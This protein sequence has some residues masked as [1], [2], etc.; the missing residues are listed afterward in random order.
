[1]HTLQRLAIVL[2]PVLTLAACGGG[3]DFVDRV[4]L[5]DPVVRFVHAAPS[6]D[7]L[8]LYRDF[9]NAPDATNVPFMFA[10]D[11]F[12]IRMDKARW[13]IKSV[14]GQT[15]FGSVDIEPGRGDKYSVV[16]V[17]QSASA[18]STSAY[19]IR[20]PFNKPLVSSTAK[21][22]LMHAAFNTGNV[23]VY[24]NTAGTDIN[25]PGVDPLI[26][27]TAFN[28]AGPASGDDSVDI[29]GG[30]YQLTITP[31]GAKSILFRGL[32]T[33]DDNRDVLLVIVPGPSMD[34]GCIRTLIK[35]DKVPGANEVDPTAPP[36][37]GCIV[38]S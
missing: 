11:Y 32:T 25:L 27:A 30:T 37:M 7:A 16:A 12:D 18:S 35:Q 9:E 21:L 8:T 31:A 1:M 26:A 19:L 23:D 29:P 34:A 17:Q 15:T 3:D 10:S 38:H 22:R 2:A 5:A 36:S 20:D 33:F 4:D 13:S 28:T 6:A 14:D 24:M